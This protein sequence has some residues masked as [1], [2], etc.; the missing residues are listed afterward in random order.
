MS[1]V[2]RRSGVNNP[3][4]NQDAAWQRIQDMQREA[5]NRALMEDQKP[6]IELVAL[7]WIRHSLTQLGRSVS[8]LQHAR[9]ESA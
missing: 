5:E 7:A 1:P 2:W 9:K 8:T 4:V 6:P 3:Y